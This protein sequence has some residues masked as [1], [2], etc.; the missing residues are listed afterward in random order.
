MELETKTPQI[1]F[2]KM[3]VF[4][5]KT[6]NKYQHMSAPPQQL[7]RMEP[8]RH[9]VRPYGNKNK[10]KSKTFV[11]VCLHQQTAEKQLYVSDGNN[12]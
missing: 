7:C 12:L 4:L 6:N 8:Q 2:D 11:R 5:I 9:K 1:N 3:R 10:I